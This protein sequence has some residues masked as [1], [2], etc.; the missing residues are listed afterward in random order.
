MWSFEHAPFDAAAV[1]MQAT[2][3]RAINSCKILK[4]LVYVLSIWT[5]LAG[6]AC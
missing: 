5:A 1:H 2:K 3:A 4:A 6:R